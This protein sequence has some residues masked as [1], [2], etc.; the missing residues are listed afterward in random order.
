MLPC[1]VIVHE[2][3]AGQVEVAAVDPVASMQAI[4]N[5]ELTDIANEISTRLQKVITAL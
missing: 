2:K 5:K 3:V 4:E 1:N